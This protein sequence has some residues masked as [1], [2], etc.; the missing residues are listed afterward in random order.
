MNT[1]RKVSIEHTMSFAKLRYIAPKAQF[2]LARIYWLFNCTQF[3]IVS[4]LRI[5]FLHCSNI[6][7]LGFRQNLQICKMENNDIRHTAKMQAKIIKLVSFAC[8]HDKFRINQTLISLFFLACCAHINGTRKHIEKHTSLHLKKIYQI[9]NTD[10]FC[11][12]S[13][14]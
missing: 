7:F 6:Y 2:E 14:R 8:L 9:V 10:L 11:S 3:C 13:D 5:W 1:H 12:P 4:K